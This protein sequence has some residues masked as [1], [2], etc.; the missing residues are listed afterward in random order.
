MPSDIGF[1]LLALS[2]QVNRLEHP[3]RLPDASLIER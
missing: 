2:D 1:S 3:A